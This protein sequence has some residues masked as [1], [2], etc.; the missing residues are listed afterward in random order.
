M[1]VRT[2]SPAQPILPERDPNAPIKTPFE[3][4]SDAFA[5]VGI[6]MVSD[7]K[8][9]QVLAWLYVFGG[10]N[11]AVV[12]NKAS[13]GLI[14]IAQDRLN[15]KGGCIPNIVLLPLLQQYTKEAEAYEAGKSHDGKDWVNAINN[16]F[17]MKSFTFELKPAPAV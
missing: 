10:G 15:L 14:R 8:C 17:N 12:L 1:P 13:N 6:K 9:C 7:D 4:M 3:D 16:Q 11:E 2:K 5:S